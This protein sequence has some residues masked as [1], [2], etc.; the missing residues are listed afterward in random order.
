MCSH[1]TMILINVFVYEIGTVFCVRTH[2]LINV[3]KILYN[4]NSIHNVYDI[5]IWVK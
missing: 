3:A 5:N 2:F 4:V 1:T